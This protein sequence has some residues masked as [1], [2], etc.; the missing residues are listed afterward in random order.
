[1]QPS[2]RATLVGLAYRLPRHRPPEAGSTCA[3]AGAAACAGRSVPCSCIVTSVTGRNPPQTKDIIRWH[4]LRRPT[5]PSIKK[6]ISGTQTPSA[7]ARWGLAA[8]PPRLG[9]RCPRRACSSRGCRPGPPPAPRPR[10]R[11]GSSRTA[12]RPGTWA[13]AAHT[14][15]AP[16]TAHS[17]HTFRK[18]CQHRRGSGAGKGNL[19]SSLPHSRPSQSLDPGMWWAR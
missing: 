10:L 9:H 5:C 12:R 4:I 18:C 8:H 2:A 15:P 14:S 16:R 19:I 6:G 1:M 7:P 17:D 3:P 11:W 13:A